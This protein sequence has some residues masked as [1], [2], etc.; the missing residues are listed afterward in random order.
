[1]FI[2]GGENIHPEEVERSLCQMDFIQQ[3]IVVP[4]ESSEFGYRPVAFIKTL[5]NTNVKKEDLYRFLEHQL[6]KFK[7]PTQ[8]YV[9]PPDSP[10]KHLKTDRRFFMKKARNENASL[11]TIN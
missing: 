7:I 1:M 2:S 6:P 3:A 11:T 4:V 9:W 5:R 10:A 8:F